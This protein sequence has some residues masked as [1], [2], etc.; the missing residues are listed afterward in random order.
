MMLNTQVALPTEFPVV[1]ETG[2]LAMEHSL[3]QV[4]TAQNGQYGTVTVNRTELSHTSF[5]TQPTMKNV[6]I[7]P[8]FSIK[9]KQHETDLG[10]QVEQFQNDQRGIILPN[11]TKIYRFIDDIVTVEKPRDLNLFLDNVTQ[12]RTNLLANMYNLGFK[13]T[14]ITKLSNRVHKKKE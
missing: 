7:M 3:G 9:T 11:N 5:S 6:L 13:E 12:A 1:L 10:K 8:P 4:S 14:K 2:K